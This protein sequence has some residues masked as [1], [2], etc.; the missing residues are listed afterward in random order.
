ML[1]AS[2]MRSDQA[3]KTRYRVMLDKDVAS[4]QLELGVDVG[5]VFNVIDGFA[6][7][8]EEEGLYLPPYMKTNQ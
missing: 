1:T 2:D 5:S 3:D 7:D 8:H 4:S 6:F